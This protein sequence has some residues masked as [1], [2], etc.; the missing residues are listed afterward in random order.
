MES[1]KKKKMNYLSNENL[2]QAIHKSKNSYCYFIDDQYKD[3]DVIV[4]DLNEV[5][6]ELIT[7][8][9]AQ[10]LKPR[11]KASEGREVSPE[12]IVI[13]LM[14]FDHIPPAGMDK[15]KKNKRGISKNYQDV[16]FPPFQHLIKIDGEFKCVG[17]S[18]WINGLENGEYCNTHGKI[19]KDLAEAIV[20]LAT[21][22]S[23][24]PNFVNYSY[25]EEFLGE[26][27][28]QLCKVSL[29]FNESKSDNPF[30]YFTQIVHNTFLRYLKSEKNHQEIKDVIL[31]EAGF[32]G[33]YAFQNKEKQQ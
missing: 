9:I 25:R 6:N 5:S 32:N 13:R 22:Y 15:G 2:R 29:Q 31:S 21:R 26:A 11:G 4:N 19:N 27:I 8:A 12:E 23:K 20:L 30:S 33:S 17:K 7:E 3:Y 18:H 14:T 1:T 16:A 28:V 10:R 24:K